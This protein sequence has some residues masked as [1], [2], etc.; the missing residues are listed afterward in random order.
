MHGVQRDVALGNG[1]SMVSLPLHALH[2]TLCT[3]L[4]IHPDVCAHYPGPVFL[5]SPGGTDP[6]AS[7]SESSSEINSDPDSN[8]S[9]MEVDGPTSE[10]GLCFAPPTH[11]VF[12]HAPATSVCTC[13]SHATDVCTHY[14]GPTFFGDPGGTFFC[15]VDPAVSSSESDSESMDL[16][17][18]CRKRRRLTDDT[19]DPRAPSRRRRAP[20]RD[21]P[22]GCEPGSPPPLVSQ[23]GGNG[24][25]SVSRA[26]PAD[27][28]P[29]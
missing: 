15:Y 8:V 29:P 26:H 21:P 24:D 6:F 2:V 4:S 5:G 12:D 10:T 17:P 14:P 13:A 16:E 18:I 7:D 19:D 9:D 28:L 3:C 27:F 22:P 20:T 25:S 11:S 1:A 23:G